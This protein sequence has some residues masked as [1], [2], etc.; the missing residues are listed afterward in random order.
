[1]GINKPDVR[2]VI[3]HT[4]PKSVEEYYQE[5]GRAGRDG[6]VSHCILY[7]SRADRV[8]C[9]SLISEGEGGVRNTKNFQKMVDYCEDEF[10]CRRLIQLKHFGEEFDPKDCNNTCDNCKSRAK[11]RIEE[12]DQTKEAKSFLKV[13]K[14]YG[15]KFGKGY[16]IKLWKGS[17]DAKIIEKKHHE[18]K[19]QTFGSGNK[20][21][22][23]E[24]EKI[25]QDLITNEYIDEE[26]VSNAGKF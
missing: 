9:L 5:S 22:K 23:N 18:E 11:Y 20:I 25:I 2:F 13:L 16:Y 14:E 15:G 8:K 10:Q 12:V 4:I 7:Y 17:K 21:T 26:V 19:Y 3:H 1:M 24:A 6:N